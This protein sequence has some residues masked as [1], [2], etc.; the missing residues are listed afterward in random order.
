M[1][2]LALILAR[3]G[4][5][6]VPAK[7]AMPIAGRPCVC[8]TIDHARQA[9]HVSRI[10]LSTDDASLQQL[11]VDLGIDIVA[12]PPA[13]ARDNSTVD[14][15][16][17]HAIDAIEWGDSPVVIL[18]ANVPVRPPGLIDR[19]IDTL[20]RTGCDSVQSY[21]PVGKHHPLWT[22]RLD[23][24][25]NVEPWEGTTLNNSIYRRQDLPPAFIPDAG[26]LACTPRALR[27]QIEGVP[28]GPHAFLGNDRRGIR[29]EPGE[30]VDIDTPIDTIVAGAILSGEH[31]SQTLPSTP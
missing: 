4:S 2:A 12:R 10:V 6:G 31:H 19:A 9:T 30:V 23:D 20:Q 11:G 18:Y 25:G 5:R 15:A 3:A 13:L 16:V 17:R 22:T 14:D 28:P 1:S 26:V 24:E 7:N 21:A 29:T 8:W 27:M